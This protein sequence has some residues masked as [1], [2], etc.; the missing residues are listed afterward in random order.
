MFYAGYTAKY[1]MGEDKSHSSGWLTIIMQE[2]KEKV[3][4]IFVKMSQFHGEQR[5]IT[6]CVKIVI[7]PLQAPTF[8]SLIEIDLTKLL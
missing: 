8:L 3:V 1:Y 4:N 2:Q 7:K 6:S 5:S